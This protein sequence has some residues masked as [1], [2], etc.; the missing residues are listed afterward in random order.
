MFWQCFGA[1]VA[2][3]EPSGGWEKHVKKCFGLQLRNTFG[4]SADHEMHAAVAGSTCRSDNA[5]STTCSELR[6]IFLVWQAQWFLRPGTG[7]KD[8]GVWWHLQ[9]K[10]AAVGRLKKICTTLVILYTFYCTSLCYTRLPCTTL[11]FN[12]FYKIKRNFNYNHATTIRLQVQAQ[13]HLQKQLLMYTTTT[14]A[15]ALHYTRLQLYHTVPH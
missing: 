9:K 14:T 10:M 7:Q 3:A 1:T 2:G 8:V 13:A 4:A 6:A 5:Q 12:Y 11:H 15:T